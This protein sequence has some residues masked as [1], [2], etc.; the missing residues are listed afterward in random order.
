MKSQLNDSVQNAVVF[1]AEREDAPAEKVLVNDI[2]STDWRLGPDGLNLS[3]V[4]GV[5]VTEDLERA[6]PG[7]TFKASAASQLTTVTGLEE[8]KSK[9][10]KLEEARSHRSQ[11]VGRP[12]SR[13][14]AMPLQPP[15]WPPP[16]QALGL[17]AHPETT[18]VSLTGKPDSFAADQ[19]TCE[20][21]LASD[22]GG[23][24]IPGMFMTM[25]EM[26]EASRKSTVTAPSNPMDLVGSE[27]DGECVS[28]RRQKRCSFLKGRPRDCRRS[29]KR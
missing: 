11:G 13:N 22:S 1:A 20:T 7:L 5:K 2:L 14:S 15:P 12:H 10:R 19:E 25:S 26:S 8:C 24:Q 28:P 4:D 21:A 17:L 23:R 9:S 29:Q 18:G 6:P 3:E 27:V 16:L